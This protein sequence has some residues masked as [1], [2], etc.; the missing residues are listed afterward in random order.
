MSMISNEAI[1]MDSQVNRGSNIIIPHVQMTTM[2]MK[3]KLMGFIGEIL[4]INEFK[5]VIQVRGDYNNDSIH[6]LN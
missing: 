6:I 5:T 2:T 4:T 1:D 3:W